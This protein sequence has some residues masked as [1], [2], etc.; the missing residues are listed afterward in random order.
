L[1]LAGAYGLAWAGHFFVQKNRPATFS[2]RLWSFMGDLK[3]YG[4]MSRGRLSAE[5]E[6]LGRR[7]LP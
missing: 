5:L 7:P 6:R 4:L 2:Y 3:M 1:A